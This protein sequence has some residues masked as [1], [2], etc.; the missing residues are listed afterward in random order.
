[1]PKA[2]KTKNL[3]GL[4]KL[5]FISA[6]AIGL[7]GCGDGSGGAGGANAEPSP[8]T[9]NGI[10]FRPT[11][12]VGPVLTMIRVAGDATQSGETGTVRMDPSPGDIP[13]TNASGVGSI[14]RVSPVITGATYTYT[15]T[16]SVGGRLVIRGTGLILIPGSGEEPPAEE[17]PAEGEPPA[18]EEPPPEPDQYE[19]FAGEFSRTYDIIYATNGTVITTLAITDYDTEAGIGSGSFTFSSGNMRLVGGALVPVGWNLEASSGL[20]LPK[21]Y[22]LKISTEDLILTFTDAPGDTQHLLLLT[23]TFTPLSPQVGDFVEKGIGNLRTGDSPTPVTIGYEY[24]PDADTT[25]K[26]ELKILR[27]G[28]ASVVYRMTFTEI[29]TGNFV[30]NRGRTGTFEFPFLQE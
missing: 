24:S 22:P 16:S 21:L 3:A 2:H 6:A 4:L 1:M 25:N 30:D 28:S 12:S 27:S 18:E 14:V 10:I 23:S 13:V 17:P 29:E 8:R 7:I 20:V 11:A 5:F 19:Y 26:V 9:M 15:R